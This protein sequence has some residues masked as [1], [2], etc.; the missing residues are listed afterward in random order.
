MPPLGVEAVARLLRALEPLDPPPRARLD[1]CT[2][3]SSPL[4]VVGAPGSGPSSS[5]PSYCDGSRRID[6]AKPDWRPE[7]PLVPLLPL[8]LGAGWLLDAV[9]GCVLAVIGCVSRGA[10]ELGAKAVDPRGLPR[11]CVTRSNS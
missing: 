9:A 4:I 1:A 2:A 5:T 7:A 8:V 3:N 10:V 6:G 11:N